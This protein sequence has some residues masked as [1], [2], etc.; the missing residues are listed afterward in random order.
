MLGLSRYSMTRFLVFWVALTNWV[1]TGD[2]AF[3][4]LLIFSHTFFYGFSC[5]NYRSLP[6]CPFLAMDWVSLDSLRDR[7][8][9]SY[10][11][12]SFRFLMIPS[13]FQRFVCVVQ[14]CVQV[15]EL[16]LFLEL[17]EIGEF[18]PSSSSVAQLFSV[19]ILPQLLTCDT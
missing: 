6:Y 16:K 15:N 17:A 8:T 5:L 10:P 12:G 13:Q 4:R 1:I 19:C 3:K 11:R 9:S 2:R 18:S 7:L 14:K